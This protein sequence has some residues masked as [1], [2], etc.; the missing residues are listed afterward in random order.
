MKSLESR[1]LHRYTLA[2]IAVGITCLFL[3]M[4]REFLVALLLAALLSGL[5]HPLY[6]RLKTAL[7]GRRAAA[8]AITVAV[9][10]LLVVVPLAGFFALVTREALHL[11]EVAQPWLQTQLDNRSELSRR[12]LESDLGQLLAPY[13]DQ[14]LQHMTSTAGMAG[15]WL[16]GGLSSVAQSTL[17]FV[18]MLFVMLYA[19]F[20]FLKDG[21]ATLYKILYYLPLPPEDEN[22]M[23]DKFVSV[24]RATIK[25]TLVI[26]AVQGALG[27]IALA[28]VGVEGALVW[29]TIMAVLSVIPGIGPTL[30][31]FPVVVYLILVQR[32][33][34]GILLFS[35]CAAVVGT[36]DNLLR[37]RLVGR[38]TEMSDLLV[39]LSTL[40]G[41][42]LFGAVGIIVGPLI[43]ALF[44]TVWDLYG[45]AFQDILPQPDIS[46]SVFP[47]PPVP[48][49]PWNRGTSRAPE[50]P[51]EI[52]RSAPTLRRSPDPIPEADD[53]VPPSE[54][55]LR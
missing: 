11:L 12:L 28:A 45:A 55:T 43:A 30:I 14:I 19:Q 37:P 47:G 46:P 42:L 53:E 9:V 48:Q 16:A 39:L 13:Q 17:T 22:R 6:S 41:M 54:T 5:F 3:W 35:W 27:G 33:T 34:A 36:V 32:Y 29:G 24:T 21:K 31:W 38:D 44:V 49:N 51:D 20:F 1:K 2:G 50:A 8:S 26:G 7:R 23:L 18:L 15:T 52:P 40:G 4:I 25:G 10:S